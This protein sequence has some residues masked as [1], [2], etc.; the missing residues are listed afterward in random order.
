MT[1]RFSFE[2]LCS[3]HIIIEHDANTGVESLTF[4]CQLER[5]VQYWQSVTQCVVPGIARWSIHGVL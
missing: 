1:T 2:T 3:L 4:K 5:F